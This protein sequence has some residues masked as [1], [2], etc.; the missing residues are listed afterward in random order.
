MGQVRSLLLLLLAWAWRGRGTG[1]TN[2][3]TRRELRHQTLIRA[4]LDA[5][6]ALLA[7]RRAPRV[8]DDPVRRLAAV[9]VAD[10]EHAVVQRLGGAGRHHTATVRHEG[11]GVHGHSDRAVVGEVLGDGVLV[12]RDVHVAGDRGTDLVPTRLAGRLLATA[13]DVG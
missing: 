4:L 5:D 9:V 3:S 8:L 6:V 12:V 10:E 13:R 11:G 7:P 2:N 1:A